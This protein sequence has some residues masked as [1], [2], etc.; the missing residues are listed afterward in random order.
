MR[1]TLILFLL[2]GLVHAQGA[3]PADEAK[4]PKV[5]EDIVKAVRAWM[6]AKRQEERDQLLKKLEAREDLDFASVKKGLT[7][8]RYYQDPILTEFGA[9]HSNTFG[10]QWKGADGNSRAFSY[11]LPKSYSKKKKIPVIMY[12]HHNAGADDRRMNG[13]IVMPHFAEL[14][15]SSN[16]LFVA[17]ST[18]QGAE[19]W[20]PEGRRYITWVINWLK[21]NFNID[22]DKIALM[23]A[24]DGGSSCWVLGQALPDMFSCLIPLSGN[25]VGITENVTPLYLGTLDRMDVMMGIT[26][27]I[28]GLNVPRMLDAIQPMFNKNMRITVRVVPQARRDVRYLPEI[29][30]YAVPFAL[31]KKRDAH[32]KEVDVISGKKNG[33]RSLWLETHGV[34]PE[35]TKPPRFGTTEFRGPASKPHKP[36]KKIGIGINKPEGWT[37]GLSLHSVQG[38]ASRAGVANGDVLMEV[39]GVVVNDLKQVKE[40]IE[41]TGW[42]KWVELTI[43]REVAED[44]V[45][46]ILERQQRYLKRMDKRWKREKEAEADGRDPLDVDDVEDDDEEDDGDDCGCST[47][48]FGDDDGDEPAEDEPKEPAANTDVLKRVAITMKKY[49]RVQKSTGPLVRAGF[50]ASWNNQNRHKGVQ[51]KGVTPG[52]FAARQ[53][54]KNSDLIVGVGDTSVKKVRQLAKWFEDY[55]FEKEPED[56]RWIDFTIKRQNAASEW[57][58]KTIR[59]KWERPHASRVDVMVDRAELSIDVK[60]RDVT[61]FTLYFNEKVIPA[62]KE[63]QLYINGVPYGDLVDPATAPNY[64]DPLSYDSLG[65]ETLRKMRKERAKVPGWTPDPKFALRDFQKRNDRML[66]FGAKRT[67]DVEALKPGFHAAAARATKQRLDRG[68]RLKAA[69]EK[70]L[71]ENGSVD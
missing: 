70:S 8:G 36:E 21:A 65:K 24:L 25:P 42:G 52:G 55:K 38:Q 14:C 45:E 46:M 18:Y 30:P 48:D 19:W 58:E 17:P 2:T 71:G 11:Y 6:S 60:A 43:V 32:A 20:M 29:V 44:D 12:L 54:F 31:S 62:G 49:V 59:V 63:F 4:K 39:G 41:A 61:K 40:A 53:G 3:S 13:R 10:A 1:N 23:G 57:E 66:V 68:A 35:G 27:G 9:R 69:Y 7:D 34:D 28:G 5:N 50:G 37:A 56:E 64:P 26:G 22:E 15:E 33:L 47:L 16:F 67:F 51:L